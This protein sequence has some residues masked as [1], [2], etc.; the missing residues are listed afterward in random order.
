MVRDTRSALQYADLRHIIPGN[1]KLA[2]RTQ[3]APSGK[4]RDN[5]SM[6]LA[7][8]RL[9]LCQSH[10]SRCQRGL[11]GQ[12]GESIGTGL[13]DHVKST[14]DKLQTLVDVLKGDLES[15]SKEEEE[16]E[17]EEEEARRS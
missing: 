9:W 15:H 11:S 12:G 6:S 3:R 14:K 2:T 17:E 8:L 4:K 5:L 10:Q 7:L 1:Q 16:E 13:S